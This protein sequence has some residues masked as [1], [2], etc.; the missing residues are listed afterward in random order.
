MC[1]WVKFICGKILSPLKKNIYNLLLVLD[2]P[3][4]WKALPNWRNEIGSS[5]FWNNKNRKMIEPEIKLR[6]PANINGGIVSTPMRIAKNVV[7][8]KKATQNKAR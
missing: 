6:I 3:Y 2:R 8:Q 1:E 4:I 5:F 7:P